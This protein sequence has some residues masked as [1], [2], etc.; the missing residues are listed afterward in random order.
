MNL[1]RIFH[2]VGQGAFYSERHFFNKKEFTIVYDC[3]SKTISGK[4]L[5]SKIKS[6]F[7]KNHIIDVLFISHFHSDHINGIEVLKNH[8][9]I[10]SVVIPYLSDEAKILIKITNL[11]ENKDTDSRLLDNPGD[12]FGN[13]TSIITIEE[14][15]STQ[16][17]N[18]IN[19]DNPVVL[20]T[21]KNSQ[22]YPNG[23]IFQLNSNVLWSYI[24]INIKHDQRKKQFVKA[25]KKLGL[26]LNK[27][28]TIN[29]IQTNKRNIYS[30]YNSIDGDLNENS[31]ILFSGEKSTNPMSCF[32]QTS[33]PNCFFNFNLNDLQS[34]CLYLGDVNLNQINVISE[35]E[36]KLIN[37]L[38]FIG[39]IQ[40]PHH[41]SIHNFNSSILQS[42]TKCAVLSYGSNNTYGHPSDCVVGDIVANKVYP[43]LITED[44]NSMIVQ[45]N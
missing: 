30:A 8:C 9:K 33:I 19:S 6:T 3:G 27:I 37:Y 7:H 17:E 28:N 21:I 42:E 40:I 15:N 35:I 26:T 36:N 29:K 45:W 16:R 11:I 34:G 10:K 4:R 41:G 24:P 18:V 44:Q 13:D 38:K 25:L 22:L 32:S 39:T 43:H 23:T 31:L 20:S 12:F 1:I 14:S 5:E 2:P